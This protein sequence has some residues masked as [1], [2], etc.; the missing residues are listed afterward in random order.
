VSLDEEIQAAKRAGEAERVEVLERRRGFLIRRLVDLMGDPVLPCEGYEAPSPAGEDRWSHGDSWATGAQL[1]ALKAFLGD[2]VEFLETYTEKAY[3]GDHFAVFRVKD[4][5]RI[6]LWRDSFGSCSGCDSM[7]G[8]SMVKARELIAATLAEGNTRQFA[9][10][11]GAK[12]YLA[13][14]EDYWWKACP[15][16]QGPHQARGEDEER[17]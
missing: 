15:L 1:D 9:S 16:F 12:H 6:V 11:E 17:P 5:G 2:R 7:E 13:T 14:C 10:I 8:E 3:Q 4:D